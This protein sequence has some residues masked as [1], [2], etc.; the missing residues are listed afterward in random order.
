[1]NNWDNQK[2]AEMYDQYTK[3]FNL[4]PKTS[5]DV[6]ERAGIEPGMRVVDL[7]CGTGV[8]SQAVLEFLGETGE[9]HSVDKATA[10]IEKAKENITSPNV[11][12]HNVAAEQ[13]AEVV[14]QGVDRLVCSSGIWHPDTEQT[15]AAIRKVMRWEPDVRVVFNLPANF[16]RG[17]DLKEAVPSGQ[18][19]KNTTSLPRVM[20]EI[21]A[22]EYGYEVSMDKMQ[23]PK[24]FEHE[25]FTDV[26]NKY[27]FEI[28]SRE[29]IEYPRETGS[30]A[31]WRNIPNMT[32]GNLPGVDYETRSEILQKALDRLGSDFT[33]D[34][35]AR[36]QLFVLKPANL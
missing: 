34:N 6:V 15:F 21:A 11:H 10:M 1:M 18:V 13:L 12:F 31:A 2:N 33:L 9:L 29:A 4:Y 3:Q 23:R 19:R 17:G 30:G 22:E 24:M 27:G 8:T 5:R 35:D 26:L 16:Y 25:V 7:C 28:E 32:T 20:I 36:F 14:P